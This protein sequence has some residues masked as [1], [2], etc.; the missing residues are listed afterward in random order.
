MRTE[1]AVGYGYLKV[2]GNSIVKEG[3][4]L[5][6]MDRNVTKWERAVASVGDKANQWNGRIFRRAIDVEEGYRLIGLNEPVKGL[7]AEFQGRTGK[8]RSIVGGDYGTPYERCYPLEKEIIHQGGDAYRTK[9]SMETKN[10]TVGFVCKGVDVAQVVISLFHKHGVTWNPQATQVPPVSD[11][12]EV[13]GYHPTLKTPCISWTSLDRHN[14]AKDRKEIRADLLTVKELAREVERCLPPKIPVINVK[15]TKGVEF[16][17]KFHKEYVEFG[18]A[19]VGNRT[20][21]QALFATN[22]CESPAGLTGAATAREYKK[23]TSINIGEG[24]F[25]V[26]TLKAI[27][28]HPH[29]EKGT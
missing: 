6:D 25:P 27:V 1:H 20:I 24:V 10:A 16:T 7:D 2:D 15:N 19:K 13:I 23:V 22:D 5:C 26:A 29:F 9:I 21:R 11:V 12:M 18:C 4:E 8:W 17:A 28:E 3:D 14:E